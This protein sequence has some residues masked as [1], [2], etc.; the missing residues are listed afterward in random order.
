MSLVK[1]PYEY[2]ILEKYP[3]D[4][5]ATNR[6]F[7]QKNLPDRIGRGRECCE[8]IGESL[9]YIFYRYRSHSDGSGGYIL[10]QAKDSS[11]DVVYFGTS[12]AMQCIFDE[13][14][15]LVNGRSTPYSRNHYVLC[16]D[17]ETGQEERC[18]WFGKGQCYLEQPQPWGRQTYCQDFVRKMFVCNKSLAFEVLRYKDGTICN[19][20]HSENIE[21]VYMLYI[22]YVNG[23]PLSS[24]DFS[25][26]Q[27]KI[28]EI[29]SPSLPKELGI[30]Q[31]KHRGCQYEGQEQ[32]CFKECSKCAIS[33]KNFGD[34]MFDNHNVDEAKKQYKRAVFTDPKYA[35]AWFKLANLFII[36]KRYYDALNALEKA[37][38]VDPIYGRA[39]YGK[40]IALDAIGRSQEAM[41]LTN[42]ILGIYDVDE[43]HQFKQTLLNKGVADI[44]K[45]ERETPLDKEDLS[46]DDENLY[47]KFYRHLQENPEVSER[48]SNLLKEVF[49]PNNID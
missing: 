25:E 8:R 2:K 15:F 28:E 14:L 47:T 20:G 17:V 1:E 38:S 39:M 43:V 24:T 18:Y 26:S 3:I 40:A 34:L 5:A 22:N 37:L 12:Q 30:D 19:K 33:F 6:L 46:E 41:L 29:V 4:I 42:E 31:S 21:A 13:K 35:E 49:R 9:R 44:S 10:R 36:E 32:N 11:K 45:E 27:S 16:R 23:R 48:L 7:E